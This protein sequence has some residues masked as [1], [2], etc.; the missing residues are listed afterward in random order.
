MDWK[1]DFG[2]ES[3]RLTCGVTSFTLDR[4][5]AVS[6]L[7]GASGL[8]RPRIPEDEI[9]RSVSVNVMGLNASLGTERQL[10]KMAGSSHR[11]G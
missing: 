9:V 3:G 4:W 2:G 6:L 1:W 10:E 5:P 7:S 8:G 11:C